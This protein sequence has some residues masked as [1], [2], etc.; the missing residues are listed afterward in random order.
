MWQWRGVVPR[1][2]HLLFAG[3]ALVACVCELWHLHVADHCGSLARLLLII[4]DQLLAAVF[5]N[6]DGFKLINFTAECYATLLTSRMLRISCLVWRPVL[7][8]PLFILPGDFVSIG[9]CYGEH[10][11]CGGFH[12]LWTEPSPEFL[13]FVVQ[14]TG[15]CCWT[16]TRFSSQSS[17]DFRFSSLCCQRRQRGWVVRASDLKYGDPEFR[18]RS[19]H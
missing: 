18:S 15:I 9:C 17:W 2:W 19:D 1:A 7:L 14:Q 12:Y 11:H 8:V 6:P 16:G 4:P 3:V 13:A 5:A 10:F